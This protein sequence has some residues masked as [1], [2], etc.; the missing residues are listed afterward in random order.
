MSRINLAFGSL[1]LPITVTLGLF[2]SA[3]KVLATTDRWFTEQQ[4]AQGQQL[5]QQHC[6]V[7]HGSNAES[8]PHWKQPDENGNYPPPPLNGSAHAWHHD[9]P[10]LR[11]QI[12]EG[13]QKL[14]GQMPAFAQVLNAGEIDAVIAFFQSLWPR[15][16]FDNWTAHFKIAERFPRSDES[17]R[18]AHLPDTTYLQQRLGDYRVDEPTPTPMQGIY[19]IRF[20]D[21]TLYL[22]QDGQFA[23]IGDMI[24]LKSGINLSQQKTD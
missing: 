23:F 18:D 11:K 17:I 9:L 20:G 4:V 15:E 21:K 3:G 14:G 13:G 1:V 16:T 2:C 10:V 8:T 6:A 24:D 7:C 5:F 19:R 12:R 22:S